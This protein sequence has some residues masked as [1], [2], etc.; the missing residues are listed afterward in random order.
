MAKRPSIPPDQ[1]G[2]LTF[3]A[4]VDEHDPLAG[5]ERVDTVEGWL[6]GLT[7]I[8]VVEFVD[9]LGRWRQLTLSNGHKVQM[10]L[11]HPWLIFEP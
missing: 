3:K 5:A 2:S 7:I 11:T 1:R 4:P 6:V 10:L 9:G 8:D